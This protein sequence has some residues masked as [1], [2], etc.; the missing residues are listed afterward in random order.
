MWCGMCSAP[1]L[2]PEIALGPTVRR[3]DDRHGPVAFDVNAHAGSE[4]SLRHRRPRAPEHPAERVEEAAAEVGRRGMCEVGA[5]AM[6]D[7]AVERELRDH[8]DATAE[9]EHRLA[10]LAALVVEDAEREDLR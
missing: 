10:E 1:A 6:P 2:S 8:Q 7:V 5:A 9:L 3:H 4:C